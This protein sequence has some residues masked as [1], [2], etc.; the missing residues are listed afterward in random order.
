MRKNLAIAAIV[1]AGCARKP[2]V[3]PGYQGV[4]ELDERVLAFEVAGRVEAVPVHRGDLVKDGQV[5]AKLDDTLER[6][7]TQNRADEER[8]ANADRALLAAGARSQDVA[9]L[10]ADLASATAAE[11]LARKTVERTR[12]LH[13]SEAVPQADLD[14]AEAD[15]ARAHEA[16]K[17]AA[18]RLA[19]L[20]AGARPEELSRATA[21]QEAARAALDLESARLDRFALHSKNDGIVL[22]VNILAGELAAVGTPAVTIADVTHPYVEV[23]VP[24]GELGGLRVGT[25]AEVKT[26]E[27]SAANHGEIEFISPKT[28]FTPRFLFSDRERPNLV[29]RVRVR[30]ADPERKLHAGVPAF[31]Q[32]A[33]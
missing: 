15:L 22:D 27:S 4:I 16:K 23:F 21:R 33:R 13:A 26:D 10:A 14:R 19:S 9:A 18:D 3:P 1:L 5:V 24:E 8:A 25:G 11:D 7:V 2:G 28:E 29:I 20:R 32:F 12:A 31:V 17:S 6:L 30:I